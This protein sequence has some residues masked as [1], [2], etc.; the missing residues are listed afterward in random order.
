LKDKQRFI[1]SNLD[2]LSIAQDLS[3]DT[4]ILRA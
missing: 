4:Q 2:F 3:D 1:T